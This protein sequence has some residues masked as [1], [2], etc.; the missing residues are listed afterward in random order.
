MIVGSK[1]VAELVNETT[2]VLPVEKDARA[3]DDA[4]AH[5]AAPGQPRVVD[6]RF[7]KPLV[8][9]Y[10]SVRLERLGA[11]VDPIDVVEVDVYTMRTTGIRAESAREAMREVLLL[12]NTQVDVGDDGNAV[13]SWKG[14]GQSR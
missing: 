12:K 2:A 10:A 5:R 4:C 11:L 1:L 9:V 14:T 8:A 7:P 6:A 3:P 13:A